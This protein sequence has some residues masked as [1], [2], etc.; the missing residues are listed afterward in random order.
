MNFKLWLETHHQLDSTEPLK[1]GDTLTVYHGF[2][3]INDAI[4]LAT[5]GLS[6][7]VRAKRRYSYEAATNPKGLFVTLDVKTAE[8]FIGSDGV[9]VE[10]VAKY[11]ELEPPVWPSGSYGIQGQYVQVFKSNIERIKAKKK[12][13]MEFKQNK[14]LPSFVRESDNPYMAYLLFVSTENQALFVGDLNP[15]RIKAF[16]VKGKKI[17]PDEFANEYG[18][19]EKSDKLFMPEDKFD[20]DVFWERLLKRHPYLKFE[21]LKNIKDTIKKSR[22]P[23]VEFL[24]AFGYYLWPKQYLPAML[25]LDK[26]F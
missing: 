26:M 2:N 13:E 16:Y 11:E 22:N 3:D 1:K 9:V 10:F 14:D 20:P 17:T 24:N 5:Q 7:K 18:S 6:G 25:W 19:G 8:K 15:S 12:F 4:N 23:K 21:N